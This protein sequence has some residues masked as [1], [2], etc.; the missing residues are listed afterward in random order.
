ME[1]LTENFDDFGPI[2]EEELRELDEE[3]KAHGGVS[4]TPASGGGPTRRNLLGGRGGGRGRG[5]GVKFDGYTFRRTLRGG[6]GK[7]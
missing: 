4:S 3:Y 7:K 6:M 5:R 2:P 1:Q